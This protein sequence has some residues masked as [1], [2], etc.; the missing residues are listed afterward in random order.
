M[1][2]DIKIATVKATR[3]KFHDY[4]AMK[5]DFTTPGK[6]K[7]DMKDYV[8]GMIEDFPERV[9][10]S[11]YPWN[12]NLFKV[13]ETATKLSKQKQ[14]LFHTFV[15]KRCFLQAWSTRYST[16]YCIPHNKSQIFR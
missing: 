4:L 14:E 11:T 7:I 9:E 8:K 6:V 15:A 12:D 3:G 10:N 13:D 2:G 5:L 16:C 1:Y